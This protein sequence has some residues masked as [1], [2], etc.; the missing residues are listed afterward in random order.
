[1]SHERRDEISELRNISTHFTQTRGSD[2]QSGRRHVFYR[3]NSAE[4]SSTD[5][6]LTPNHLCIGYENSILKALLL[7]R[8]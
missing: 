3:L 4:P 2:Q 1:M 6:D 8:S 5:I 7:K